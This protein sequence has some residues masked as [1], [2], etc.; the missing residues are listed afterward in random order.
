M[1]FISELK[2]RDVIRAF[3]FSHWEKVPGGWMRAILIA[4]IINSAHTPNLS[5][6]ERGHKGFVNP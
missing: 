5:R 2:R 4:K 6:W 1:N 3:S